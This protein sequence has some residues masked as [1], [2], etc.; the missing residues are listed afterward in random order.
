LS[1]LDEVYSRNAFD[2][3][4]FINARIVE[5][6]LIKEEFQYFKEKSL[7]CGKT[8]MYTYF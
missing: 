3:Y 5:S 6:A 1:V 8:Y 2:I 7:V 4:A